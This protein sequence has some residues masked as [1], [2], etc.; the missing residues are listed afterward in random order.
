LL[1]ASKLNDVKSI[2][3]DLKL[4][5]DLIKKAIMKV[6]RRSDGR[7][8]EDAITV[9]MH[10]SYANVT[11]IWFPSNI[12]V[13][14]EL[15]V[16]SFEHRI[17]EEYYV[18]HNLEY[19][20]EHFRA[21]LHA[22]L[23]E[24]SKTDLPT[25]DKCI[26][27]PKNEKLKHSVEILPCITFKTGVMLYDGRI[28]RDISTYP[29]VHQQNGELKDMATQG[30]FKRMVRLFKTLVAIGVRE[31]PN[32]PLLGVKTRGYFIECLLFNVPNH[33]LSGENLGDVFLKVLNYLLHADFRS[34]VCQNRIWHLFGDAAEFW[35]ERDAHLF[36]AALKTIAKI[37]PANRE[38]LI[39]TA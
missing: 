39:A 1:N 6:A 14:V 27:L 33:V 24:I 7:V 18:D 10:G 16:P 3:G 9:Y 34:Y 2:A 38:K 5:E 13:A 30:N 31:Y 35:N 8:K 32:D 29:R 4:A 37:F 11:N 36:V 12:E 21:D 19:T 15:R 25:T 17:I 20:P 26:I 28:G 23:C 22:A